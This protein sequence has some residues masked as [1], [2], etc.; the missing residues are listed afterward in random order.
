MG[1]FKN[2]LSTTHKIKDGKAKKFRALSPTISDKNYRNWACIFM[3]QQSHA[4]RHVLWN[5]FCNDN[6]IVLLKKNLENKDFASPTQIF[7]LLVWAPKSV[8]T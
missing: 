3:M 1:I 7:K 5:L 8:N 2:V 4:Q 6:N